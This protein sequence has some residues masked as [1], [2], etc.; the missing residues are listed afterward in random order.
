[1]FQSGTYFHFPPH[2]KINLDYW[3][4]LSRKFLDYLS[5]LCFDTNVESALQ[6]AAPSLLS[7]LQKQILIKNGL[8]AY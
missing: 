3:R 7:G 2:K 1:M 8:A 5:K 6:S 4:E